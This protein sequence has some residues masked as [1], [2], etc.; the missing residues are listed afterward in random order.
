[1]P[2]PSEPATHHSTT[3]VAMAP[4]SMKKKAAT[5]ADVEGGHGNGG[6]RN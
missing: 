2:M 5:G 6:D 1:M 4:Q 3:A